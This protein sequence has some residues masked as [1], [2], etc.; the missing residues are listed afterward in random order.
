MGNGGLHDEESAAFIAALE[1]ALA[2]S[3]PLPRRGRWPMRFVVTA[4]PSSGRVF[5]LVE[6]SMTIGSAPN[7][8]ITLDDA[9]VAPHHATAV[10]A[11]PGWILELAPNA[12]PFLVNGFSTPRH[13]LAHAAKIRMGM[14]STLEFRRALEDE[15]RAERDEHTGLL[16]LEPFAALLQVLL[17]RSTIE[18]N[19]FS[20]ALVDVDHLARRNDVKGFASGNIALGNVGSALRGMFRRPA[21]CGRH[22]GD[23]FAIAMPGEALVVARARCDELRKTLH[24]VP[25]SIGVASTDEGID[26]ALLLFDRADARLRSAKQ[27]GRNRVIPAL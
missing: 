26:T 15:Y 4:G 13:L 21:F 10:A 8:A 27:N 5:D 3:L 2:Q 1:G 14:A 20:F 17:A 11:D 22:T 7:C 24:D 12:S 25:V 23:G 18:G 19:P 6:P 16:R 9:G